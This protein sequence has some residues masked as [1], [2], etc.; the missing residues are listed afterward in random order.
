MGEIMKLKSAVLAGLFVCAALIAAAPASATTFCVPSF[1]AA[2]PD[3]G[4]NVAQADLET[5]MGLNGSD[6]TPDRVLVASH[7][8]TDSQTLEPAGTDP[9]TVIGTG[10]DQTF[11]TSSSSGN[12]FVVNL[13]NGN[14]EVTMRDLTIIVPASFPDNQGSGLQSDDSSFERVNFDIRNPGADAAPSLVG[15]NV[16]ED[17]RVFASS[18]G[19]V[20]RGFRTNAAGNP[21]SLR[22]I[23]TVIEGASTGVAAADSEIPVTIRGTRITQPVAYGVVV[24]DGAELTVVNSIIE[25]G[26]QNGIFVV[27][28]SNPGETDAS[29]T[30]RNSTLV[31]TGDPGQI[32]IGITI[33]GGFGSHSA[34][35][36]VTESIMRGF[37]NTWGI[38]V[39]IG[40]GVGTPGLTLS[41]SNFRPEGLPEDSP[42]VDFSDPGNIDADPL[43][44]GPGNYRLSPGSPSIDAG[45]N[46]AGGPG[47]DFAGALRPR[48]GNGDGI[49]V[50]DQ[51][52]FE[53]ADTFPPKIT[54][55]KAKKLRRGAIRISYRLSEAARVRFTF[56]PVP[57]KS[58]GKKR[59]AP[60]IQRNARRGF[61]TLVVK[62]RRLSG[63]L[64]RLKLVARD[65]YGN[66]SSKSVRAR[67]VTRRAR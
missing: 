20:D 19:T 53:R 6:G 33:G 43:F 23:D 12:V 15:D 66:A 30:I 57:A 52:A 51:G 56:K 55:L 1:T 65:P 44:V 29:A 45:T 47:N 5:A 50:R 4:T 59:K 36:L 39:P 3:N 46:A 38:S 58:R 22:I 41:D 24:S 54:G 49:A 13:N 40:P 31:S 16:F 63:G 14:R 27:T 48:D 28:A 11:I 34:T 21:G 37:D 8:H 60:K 25:S 62:G 42:H 35:V 9:L 10:T 17:C 67:S 32:P 18:G 61:N 2:C 64:Y 26:S 7:T